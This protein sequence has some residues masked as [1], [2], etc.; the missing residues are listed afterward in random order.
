MAQ[1]PPYLQVDTLLE[2]FQHTKT[3][4]AVHVGEEA[5]IQFANDAMINIWGKD[6][7][8][9]GKSLEAALPELKEQPFI[10]MF[11][12]VWREGL[13]I[14]GSDTPAELIINGKRETFFF[15]FEYKAILDSDGKTICILHTATD[16]TERYLKNKIYEKAIETEKSLGREQALNE[17]LASSNE[18]LMASNEELAAAFEEIRTT[19]EELHSTKDSLKSLNA[20]LEKRVAQ[21]LETISILNQQLEA[22]NEEIRAS[23]EE[24]LK[25]NEELAKSKDDLELSIKNL[26]DSEYRTRTIIESAPFPIG[27]YLGRELRIAFANQ[28]ILDVW[29]KGN[30]VI[31]K[32]YTE[33]L[34]EL[35]NQ[36]VFKQLDE[37]FLTGKPFIA[38]NQA[39]NLKVNGVLKTSFFNYNFTALR[40]GS[41][42]IYGVMNTAADVSDLE[43][44]RQ[45]IESAAKETNRLNEQL[46]ALN[47]EL[48]ASNEE[49]TEYNRQLSL[50]YEQLSRNQD[51]LELAINAANLG[52]FDLNPITGRFT[53]NDLLK[54][55]FGLAPGE[56]I[57]LEHAINVITESE[58]NE[59]ASAIQHSLNISSGGNYEKEYT[60]I[61]SGKPR[62]VRAKGKALFNNKGQAIRL[63]GVL[64]DVTEQVNYR[65]E[66]SEANT[67]LKIAMDAGALGSTEVDLETGDMEC[68]DRFKA[69][70]GR[71]LDEP[72]SY[73]QLFEAMLPAYRDNVRERV[74]TAID[75]H[76]I[77]QAEY[78]VQWPDE[79]IHW[80]NA[81]G[82]ARYDN[83]GKAIKMVGIVADI[84]EAK[85]DEQRKS[86]F[87]GMVS[88]ELKTPLTSISGYLQ[89][90]QIRAR[91]NEDSFS[92]PALDKATNQ[93]KKMT[94]MINSFLNMSRLES[95]KIHIENQ[96]FDLSHLVS[97][98]E[99]EFQLTVTSHK[100]IFT[101]EGEAFVNA[102]R[103]K[104][105][106]VINNFISNAIKYSPVGSTINIRCKPLEKAMQV[107][108]QD[109]G[110]GIREEDREKLFER[111][112]RVANQPTTISGFGIG[113]YL[114]AEI[115]KRHNGKIWVESEQGK[116]STFYFT[117]S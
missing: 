114:C 89:L 1:S 86:D 87:I 6:K 49:M 33:I 14:G 80:I 62:I 47:E 88:H 92:Q 51:E 72:F 75:T 38:R 27:V 26:A 43:I 56:E 24:L 42:K 36:S 25:S 22:S 70:Y 104:I 112:Y 65:K 96:Y 37:V 115:I 110:Y 97:E 46:A 16:V 64:Q 15:D 94:N 39:L 100:L 107:S 40:D 10:E 18:E 74:K 61:L 101:S 116:G 78:E 44:A 99:S 57:E 98:I 2:I 81:H 69:C 109:Q 34:P 90:L 5:Y 12:K 20:S 73:P 108:V 8:V 17:E 58:R 30:D 82:R 83:D 91:K 55:W 77:Y 84:T 32:C 29:G 60:I 11:A 13:T 41:G 117:I 52:T 3:A 28:S 45:Q 63:S 59:V 67:R 105:G 4:T 111:Y 35:E 79:T 106:Q 48:I 103:D 68:S 54:S 66:I 7:S 76:S 23:N 102:D 95:G 85:A 113:L 31:G 53:G 9:I 93:L 71:P 19:N 21:R 50:L